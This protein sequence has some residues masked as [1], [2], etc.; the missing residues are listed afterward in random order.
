[1]GKASSAAA[2]T[3]PAVSEADQ[4]AMA[5]AGAGD[6][7][8]AVR[9]ATAFNTAA[10]QVSRSPSPSALAAIVAPLVVPSSGDGGDR[11]P[12]ATPVAP[13]GAARVM[14]AVLAAAL[15]TGPIATVVAEP[16]TVVPL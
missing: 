4:D 11:G 12:S 13:V 6:R 3:S 9:I 7:V 5:A 8:A 15:T 10:I 16:P 2:L 14:M 1:M